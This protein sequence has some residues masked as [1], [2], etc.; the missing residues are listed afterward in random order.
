[1][2]VSWEGWGAAG[3]A[4]EFGQ[5]GSRTYRGTVGESFDSTGSFLYIAPTTTTTTTTTIGQ[6]KLP[7]SLIPPWVHWGLPWTLGCIEG[8]RAVHK[9]LSI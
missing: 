8:Y 7:K 5:G 6:T 2:G 4:N 3:L 9:I 1:M